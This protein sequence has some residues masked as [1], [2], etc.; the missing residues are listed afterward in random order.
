MSRPRDCYAISTRYHAE[1]DA[2]RLTPYSAFDLSLF[3]DDVVPGYERTVIVRLALTSPGDDHSRPLELSR[4]LLAETDQTR[5][6]FN[7]HEL[8][9][10]ER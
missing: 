6:R 4:A 9:G 3:G 5:D 8:K 2:D 7:E 1:D 10:T